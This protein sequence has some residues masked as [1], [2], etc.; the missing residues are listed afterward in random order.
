MRDSGTTDVQKVN[1]AE[2]IGAGSDENDSHKYGVL[3]GT[4]SSH[5]SI[6][7]ILLTVHN[8]RTLQ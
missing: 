1:A 8:R 2:S 6:V 4:T 5:H 3:V 7:N